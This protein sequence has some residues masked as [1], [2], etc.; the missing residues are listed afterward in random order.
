[1][2]HVVN[3]MTMTDTIAPGLAPSILQKGERGFSP[4]L[5]GFNEQPKIES[6]VI[7]L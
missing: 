3:E 1:M 4:F 5:K 6:S 7:E 2:W